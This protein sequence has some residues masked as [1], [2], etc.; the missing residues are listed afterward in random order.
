MTTKLKLSPRAKKALKQIHFGFTK[1]FQV[2][3]DSEFVEFILYEGGDTVTFR[4]YN[5][6]RV[7]ER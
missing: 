7:Y 6:G 5:D 3:E 4:V 2:Y 1:I